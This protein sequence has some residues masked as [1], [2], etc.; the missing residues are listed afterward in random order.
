MKNAGSLIR[1]GLKIMKDP[2]SSNPILE[3]HPRIVIDGLFFQ[4]YQFGI[5]R[6]WKSYLEQWAGTAFAEHLVI[7]DR[8]STAPRIPGLT[9]QDVPPF[10]LNDCGG[11]MLKIEEWC[12]E[13]H[14]DLFVSTYYSTPIQTPSVMMI[15]D[16][17]PEI[18][19]GDKRQTWDQDEKALA[20]LHASHIVAISQNTAND[21]RKYY[22]FLSEEDFSVVHCGVDPIFA[23]TAPAGIAA[24]KTKFDLGKPYFL[25]VGTRK[26]FL[27]YKNAIFLVKTLDQ[28]KRGR[29]FEIVCVGGEPRLEELGDFKNVSVRLLS[30]VAEDDLIALYSGAK[31][32]VYP[33]RYEGFGLPIVEA[34]ACGCPVI[35]CPNGS[36]PEVAGEAALFVKDDDYAGLE[37]ALLEVLENP[38]RQELQA[39]GLDRVQLFS[40]KKAA[41]QLS[42]VLLRAAAMPPKSAREVRIWKEFR[43]KERR[44]APELRFGRK[45][46][47]MKKIQLPLGKYALLI[48]AA[49]RPLD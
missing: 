9:Y 19:S 21:V 28:M 43:A 42:Q 46:K 8:N 36:I 10:D 14:A 30:H 29:D 6:L 27:G 1:P 20:L 5:A 33:S 25:V 37:K 41:D 24:A 13:L 16:M 22:P 15:Y 40:W 2:L 48:G 38:V 17:I 35:T 47:N 26:G 31:A 12:Q 34:M 44:L 7:L 18:Q 4:L 32:L 11:E 39:K 45:V 49:R 23:R 3:K